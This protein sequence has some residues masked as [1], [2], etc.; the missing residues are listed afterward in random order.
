[1][2]KSTAEDIHFIHNSFYG[3]ITLKR[4][5]AQINKLVKK[6]LMTDHGGTYTVT[7]FNKKEKK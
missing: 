4:V 3:P 2:Y 1:M 7:E 6:G 5:K